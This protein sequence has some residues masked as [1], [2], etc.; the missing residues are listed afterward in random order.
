MVERYYEVDEMGLSYKRKGRK[1]WPKEMTEYIWTRDEGTCIYCGRPG[2]Q[3]DHVVPVSKGGPTIQGNGV[4]SC[5]HCNGK[6]HDRF[7]LDMLTRA[8]YYLSTKGEDT[9]WV[10][11]LWSGETEGDNGRGRQKRRGAVPPLVT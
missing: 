8:L 9:S 3:I 4:L 5:G 7:P 1:S 10:D 6:K 2:L 11:L